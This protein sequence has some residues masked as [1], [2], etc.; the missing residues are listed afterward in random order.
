MLERIWVYVLTEITDSST[1]NSLYECP[2]STIEEFAN[3]DE[4][5]LFI[6]DKT[7]NDLL[8]NDLEKYHIFYS[9]DM[10]CILEKK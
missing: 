8:N 1:L 10:A 5:Y 4:K 9:I 3:S 6:L 7:N 2:I